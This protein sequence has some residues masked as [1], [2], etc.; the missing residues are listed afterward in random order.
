MK[1]ILLAKGEWIWIAEADD[2]SKPN[3]WKRVSSK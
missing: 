3:F 1:G 2:S